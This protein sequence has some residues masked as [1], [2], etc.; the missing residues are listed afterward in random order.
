MAYWWD[1]RFD[2][3]C[4]LI[5][6]VLVS[7][8]NLLDIKTMLNFLKSKE[9]KKT[10]LIYEIMTIWHT[11]CISSVGDS[12]SL[13]APRVIVGAI[14][15]F[16][17]SMDNLCRSADFDD[18]KF[19]KCTIDMLEALEYPKEFLLPIFMNFYN[20]E[21][22]QSIFA[23]SANIEGGRSVEIFLNNKD[24]AVCSVFSKLV[25]EWAANPEM[26]GEDLYLFN[27]E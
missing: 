17:G 4:L 9:Q 24:L 10:D 1:A 16:V 15:F 8:I 18:N 27:M 7:V 2:F 19:M 12:E 5:W 11:N 21:K 20:P 3:W 25:E 22:M 14:L 23:S 13:K 26:T 6:L